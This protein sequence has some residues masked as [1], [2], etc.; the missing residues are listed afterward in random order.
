MQNMSVVMDDYDQY[1]QM[2]Q[3]VYCKREWDGYAQCQCNSQIKTEV[4]DDEDYAT[5]FP[6]DMEAA[7]ESACEHTNK[8]LL[9]AQII[10]RLQQCSEE[11]L[12][13]IQKSV[14][15]EVTMKTT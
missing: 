15:S 12:I 3:C 1:T 2:T 14:N 5:Q 7:T 8:D 13:E 11:T 10:A 6:M 9:I 4:A